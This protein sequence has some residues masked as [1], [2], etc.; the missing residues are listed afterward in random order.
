MGII[1]G[2]CHN[3]NKIFTPLGYYTV[4]NVS[5]QPIDPI[6]KGHVELDP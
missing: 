3:V 2:F 5:G 4:Q 6:F 1:S